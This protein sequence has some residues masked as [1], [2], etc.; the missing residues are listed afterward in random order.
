MPAMVAQDW[1]VPVR[2]WLAL[3]Y[4]GIGALVVAYLLWYRGVKVLGA[5]RTAMYANFQP[6]IALI[7]AWLTLSETPTVFQAIGAATIVGGVLLTRVPA[8]EVS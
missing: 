4:S 2:A 3:L 1:H 8:S 5:T 7:V 6:I